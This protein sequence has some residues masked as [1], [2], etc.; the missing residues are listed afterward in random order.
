VLANGSG[1]F[2]AGGSWHIFE[3]LSWLA[4]AKGFSNF[5]ANN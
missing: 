1:C 5:R 3:S 4:F 2:I